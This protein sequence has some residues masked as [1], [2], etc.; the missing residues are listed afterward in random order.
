MTTI[1]EIAKKAGVSIGTVDRV[2]HKRGRVS[3]H[4][5]DRVNRIIHEADYKPNVFASHLSLA[6]HYTFAVLIPKPY[7]DSRYW[8]LP[9]RGI[10]KA[11]EELKATKVR[12]RYF[13]YDKYSEASFFKAGEK[14]L[15]MRTELDGMVLAPVLAKAA[16]R[17]LEKIPADLPYVFIDSTVPN[18]RCL[19]SIVQNPFRSGLLAA[20]LMDL[21]LGGCGTV[22]VFRVQPLD[23]HIEDRVNGFV[24]Y[25]AQRKTVTLVT[26]D[27]DKEKDESVFFHLVPSVLEQHP[28][29]MGVF[30]PNACGHQVAEYLKLRT[31]EA[32]IRLIGYDLVDQNRINLREGRIDF[33][34]SQRPEIQGYQGIQ[35]L[36]QHLLLRN[37]VPAAMTIPLD[38]VTSEN[39]D[40]YV[41][42]TGSSQRQAARPRADKKR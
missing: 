34:I 26:V 14:V 30:I 37:P 5:Q 1:R 22:A 7:Q 36:Y 20:R 4:T 32:R 41:E 33:I 16:E 15:R 12:V 19:S 17:F 18:A 42:Y 28:E 2:I 24:S 13:H 35:I 38:I 3:K 9:L 39:L 40:D 21:L 27:A 6:K 10:R 31:M 23:Y 29:V 25:F 11:E 8:E